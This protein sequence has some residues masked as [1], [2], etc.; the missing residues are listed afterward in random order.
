[1]M[2]APG[3]GAAILAYGGTDD[4]AR[5]LA[6]VHG[7]TRP[8]DF[9]VIV[10]N[11]GSPLV[12]YF[13]ATRSPAAALIQPERNLGVGGGHALAWKT[14]LDKGADLVWVFEG[15]GI[16]EPDCLERLLEAYAAI[17][18]PGVGVVAPLQK[19]LETGKTEVKAGIANPTEPYFDT[20]CS[21]NAVLIPRATIEA[22]GLPRSDL[23]FSCE[24]MAFADALAKAKLNVLVVPTAVVAHRW[25]KRYL[26]R[27]FLGVRFKQTTLPPWRIYYETRNQTR[28]I[29]VEGKRAAPKWKW[30]GR[31][32]KALAGDLVVG[33][34]RLAQA[35]MRIRGF[36]DAYAGRMGETIPP[37]VERGKTAAGAHAS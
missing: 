22:T 37:P 25:D 2:E 4:L 1:M 31:T 14:A 21:F 35:S 16:P 9:T 20:G 27:R 28:L 34:K 5:C 7:Q 13:V 19:N 3:V 11:A 17:S 23:F 30:V 24:D 10:D 32:L 26:H 36:R 18:L 33:P 15:D 6:A 8:P 12:R 29:A